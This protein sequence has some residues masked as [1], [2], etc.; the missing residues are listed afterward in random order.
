MQAL[1]AGAIK[2]GK[3]MVWVNIVGL[4]S[5]IQL[6]VFAHFVGSARGKYGIK[7][8]AT[9][10][11]PTFEAWFRV[12]ANTVEMSIVYLPALWLAAR[13]WQPHYVALVGLVYLVGRALFAQGYVKHPDKRGLGFGISYLAV[14]VLIVAAMVGAVRELLSQQG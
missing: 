6:L 12:Q 14:A 4:L 10:G 11:H 5:L 8:P 1:A 2:K 13:Y 7:A 3:K 9:T